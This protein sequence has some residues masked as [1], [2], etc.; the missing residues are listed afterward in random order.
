MEENTVVKVQTKD[1]ANPTP[2][3]LVAFAV[4]CFCFFA[5][6]T[7]KVGATALPLLGCWLIGGFTI[8]IVVGIVDLKGG[9]ISGGNVFLF[10]SGFFML[11]GG[12]EM[13]M[14]FNAIQAGSPLDVRIDG[15]AWMVLFLVIL[16]WTPAFCA[17]F[18]L[19]SIIILLLD[20][21]LPVISLSDLGILPKTFAPVAAW[22]L[23][24]CGIIA[25]YLSAALVVNGVFGRKVYPLP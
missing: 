4:A 9:N 17:K 8:Q 16:L 5:L 18:S 23:L 21:A 1:W 2:A 20:I 22:T 10:F 6:L 15:Y 3:G 19:L 25:I 12:L 7:G 11:T 24:A 14:K 13:I